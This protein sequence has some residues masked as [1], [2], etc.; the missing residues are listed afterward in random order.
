MNEDTKACG[1]IGDN[2]LIFNDRFKNFPPEELDIAASD[3]FGAKSLASAKLSDGDKT[4][5]VGLARNA[6]V[7]KTFTSLSK[8]A[9]AALGIVGQFAGAAFVILDFVNHEWKGAA[10]GAVGLAA[11]IGAEIAISGPIGWV[12]GA[13]IA[14]FF[15]CTFFDAPMRHSTCSTKRQ[16]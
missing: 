6:G 15:A 16:D 9:L 4:V 11:G 12:I 1:S 5:K 8:N 10:I 2:E 13:A 7:L 3:T 14:L